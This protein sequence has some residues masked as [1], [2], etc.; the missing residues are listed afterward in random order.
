MASVK[1][2]EDLDAWKFARELV[3]LI[4]DLTDK[5]IFKRDY[6]LKDQMR[7]AT[8]SIMSNIAEGFERGSDKDFARFLF[9]AK[10]SCGEM[11]SQLYVSIDR[12]YIT[13]E[14]FN[15]ATEKAITTSQKISGLIKYLQQ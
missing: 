11:R 3:N 12:K 6:G 5:E 13:Q 9:I 2:F 4:Y 14:E 7:R 15:L 8:V 1:R 10:A